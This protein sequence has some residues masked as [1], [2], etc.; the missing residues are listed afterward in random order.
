MLQQNLQIL[1]K[2]KSIKINPLSTCLS[3]LKG[4]NFVIRQRCKQQFK[5][6]VTIEKM[7]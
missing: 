2:S 5:E 4:I 7:S 1:F 3:Y 6:N